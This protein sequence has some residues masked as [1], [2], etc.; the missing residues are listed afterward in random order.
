M[1]ARVE[2]GAYSGVAEGAQVLFRSGLRI[3]SFGEDQEGELYVV[4]HGG[5]IYRV[6]SGR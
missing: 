6:E 5:G 3:S 2:G 1:G 4:D